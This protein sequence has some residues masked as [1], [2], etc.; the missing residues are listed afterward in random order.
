MRR[1]QRKLIIVVALA[2][3]FFGLS[4]GILVGREWG[5]PF[6][7]TS[8]RNNWSIGIYTGNSP[9][10]LSPS[11]K[12]TNPVLTA[13]DISDVDAKFV[14]DPFLVRDDQSWIM[15]FEVLNK[16]NQGDIGLATSSDGFNWEYQQIVLDEDFHLSYPHVF[17]WEGSY[18]MTPESAESGSVRL[19][20]AD[21]FPHSWSF[22]G[23]LI[24][25]KF[26]DPTIFRHGG[27]WW[28]F[29]SKGN[30]T[31]HLFHA[32]QLTGP[33]QEHPLSP[34][35]SE[36]P[37]IARSA[38][39]IITVNNRIFRFAQ[40]D[41]PVYGNQV[42][43]FEILDLDLG[44]FRQEEIELSPLI[45]ATGSGWN[46][47]GMHHVDPVSIDGKNWIAAVDGNQKIRSLS[48]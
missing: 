36:N 1:D 35:V 22:L 16:D 44:T 10:S 47:I 38:G 11:E 23:D 39:R 7:K 4:I 45:K 13:D 21:N 42:R 30:K 9:F 40:D 32:E 34:V 12:V 27:R 15:F 31:L 14:A 2:S 37:N 33:W 19:Y 24:S 25:G 26:V 28:M 20:V 18:Y 48:W 6:P 8:T 41:A 43:L 5:I 17:E 3:L 29:A 46:A